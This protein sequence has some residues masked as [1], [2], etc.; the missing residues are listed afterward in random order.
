M[1]FFSSAAAVQSM[2][3]GGRRFGRRGF[4]AGPGG[5][6][7]H[8]NLTDL[9]PGDTAVITALNGG[10]TY[11][12]KLLSLGLLPG[13]VIE[14]VRGGYGSGML[15]RVGKSTLM[16]NAGLADRIGVRPIRG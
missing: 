5:P 2:G 16:I 9:V 1:R 12:K 13:S 3:R 15:V 7:V 11:R 4:Q 10:E 14:L 6:P 8:P